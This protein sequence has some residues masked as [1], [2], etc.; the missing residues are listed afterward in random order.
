MGHTHE[1]V[2]QLFGVVAQILSRQKTF[3]D[4]ADVKLIVQQGLQER[5]EAK[6]EH[7]CV[8]I[9]E[10]VRNFKTWLGVTGVTPHHAFGNRDGVEAPR[11]FSWKLR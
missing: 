10:E 7:L 4:P 5:I 3:Q 9:L 11:A 6:G 1:D 8:E 2:D